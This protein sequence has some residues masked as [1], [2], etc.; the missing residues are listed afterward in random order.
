M[1]ASRQP[2]QTPELIILGPSVKDNSNPTEK[3][4]NVYE[5]TIRYGSHF[6]IA[7]PQGKPSHTFANNPIP[8]IS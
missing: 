6:A 1:K 5:G 7:G 3:G 8:A 2:Y 4:H